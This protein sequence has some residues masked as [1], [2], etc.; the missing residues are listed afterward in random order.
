MITANMIRGIMAQAAATF[1]DSGVSVSWTFTDD[2]GIARQ[3]VVDAVMGPVSLR[4]I[5]MMA[6]DRVDPSATL[7]MAQADVDEQAPGRGLRNNDRVSVT[8]SD[9][10]SSIYTVVYIPPSA[11]GVFNALIGPQYG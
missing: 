6:G 9:G 1:A 3:A 5:S 2:S 7:V 8:K 4:T 11:G 10:S